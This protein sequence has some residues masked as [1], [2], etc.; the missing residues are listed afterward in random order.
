MEQYPN[1][2]L[3]TRENKPPAKEEKKEIKPVVQANVKVKKRSKLAE[4]FLPEDVDNVK[5]YILTDI[6]VP[7]IKNGIDDTIHMILYGSA[8]GGRRYDDGGG[9]RASYRSYWDRPSRD[10]N[11]DRDRGRDTSDKA[12]EEIIFDSRADAERVLEAMEEIIDKYKLVSVADFYDLAGMTCNY[13]DQKYGW[14]SLRNAYVTRYGGGYI[15]KL[16]RAMVLD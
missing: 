3:T 11:R 15:V 1:N 6:V 2:S 12:S 5:S 10:K 8:G 9:R 16:P 7:L 14:T 4:L 13:T